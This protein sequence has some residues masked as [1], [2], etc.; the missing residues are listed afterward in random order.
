V[1][2]FETGRRLCLLFEAGGARY[3]IEATSVAEVAQ[4]DEGGGTLRDVLVLQD[5]S[6]LL[7]GGEEV[8]PGMALVLDVS[9]TLAVR[10]AKVIEVADVAR[11]EFFM[12]P[13]NLGESL[14][15]HTRGALLHGGH[16]YLELVAD[17]LPHQ[18]SKPVAPLP[19]PVFLVEGTP[20]RALV[21]E[22]Q[23]RVYG[24]PLT[25]VS[26]VIPSGASF[27]A[28]PGGGGPVAG[29][30]PHAQILWPI[31]SAAGLL[32]GP[33]MREEFFVLTE[34]AGQ[35]VGLCASRVLGVHQDFRPAPERGE[36]LAERVSQPILFLDLQ[37][38]FS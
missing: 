1:T 4:P 23:G 33:A 29:F 19:R 14:T 22:S 8:R 18:P 6:Q 17:A 38:M 34:L 20:D 26:Q 15:V 21:F 36:F 32:G 10:I 9:P 28:F 31:Y 2:H 11:S 5:L 12:L 25:F 13:P 27:C 24:V 35:N 3:A 7:G 37:R 16:L 30:Q